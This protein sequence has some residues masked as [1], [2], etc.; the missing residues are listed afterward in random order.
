MAVV[1]TLNDIRVITP[2][3]EEKMKVDV[4]N[5]A[6]SFL[7]R[8]FTYVFNELNVK[9]VSGFIDD[10]K[11]GQ[12]LEEF[13]YHF[14]VSDT[15]MFRD[16]A[17]W[18]T[19]KNKIL[20]Q[21]KQHIN[22]WFPDFVSAEEL[23]SLLVILKE[24]DMLERA[25]IY[26]NASSVKRVEEAKEAWVSGIS[27]E[28]SKQ[29]FKRLELTSAF[30]DYF[31]FENKSVFIDKKLL[32]DVYFIQ[33]NFF[34]EGPPVKIDLAL[35]RNRMIYFNGKLQAQAEKKVC[36]HMQ[37]EGYLAIGIKEHIS[38]VNNDLFEAYDNVEQ[39]YKV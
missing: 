13:I 22:I 20:P 5:F 17:F 3:L 37:K 39:I 24:D 28:I 26:C 16:P 31:T 23:F 6:L 12:L 36:D 30:E 29:N 21:Y 9:S 27:Y 2:V 35:Y 7:R 18:R 4:Y 32:K 11:S 14:Q 38:T 33:R 19:L 25:N 34:L 15:E 10:I 1:P 8:R